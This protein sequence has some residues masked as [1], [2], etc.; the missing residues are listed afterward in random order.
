M[1]DERKRVADEESETE[2]LGTVGGLV[3]ISVGGLYDR[4]G[5][6]HPSF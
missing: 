5:V 3:S 1:E 4:G 2:D 6:Q